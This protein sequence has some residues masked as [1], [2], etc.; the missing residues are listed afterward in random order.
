M[1]DLRRPGRPVVRIPGSSGDDLTADIL[2]LA[3]SAV[4]LAIAVVLALVA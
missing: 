3:A 1:L 2:R 4:T